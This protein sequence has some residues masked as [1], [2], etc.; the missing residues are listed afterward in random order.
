MSSA[1]LAGILCLVPAVS[2]WLAWPRRRWAVW[3]GAGLALAVWAAGLGAVEAGERA[4]WLL[5]GIWS[6]GACAYV[7]YVVT[8]N[9]SECDSLEAL[10]AA[11][12]AERDRLA[13]ELLRSRSRSKDIETEQR[14]VLALY[15]MVKGLSEALTWEDIRPKLELAVQQYLRVEEFALYVTDGLAQDKLKVLARRRLVSG[16][17]ASWDTLQRV[18]QERGLPITVPHILPSPEAAMALP[19][20]D[21]TALQGYVYAR[22]PPATEPQALLRKGQ[23]FVDDIAFAF[24][25]VRIFQ[26]DGSASGGFEG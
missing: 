6:L 11:R 9:V 4:S 25:R 19:I 20:F 7:S 24:R 23:T 17:G 5:V 10:V 14:E 26:E 12:S 13:A 2:L 8:R 15:G 21:G 3:G 18:L 1:V 16:T 22:I